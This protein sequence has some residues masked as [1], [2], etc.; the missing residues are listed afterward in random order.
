MNLGY[1]V[2]NIDFIINTIKFENGER[3]IF[4]LSLEILLCVKGKKKFK[5]GGYRE[6]GIFPHT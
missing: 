5:G 3:G 4:E 1:H 2:Y 6:G